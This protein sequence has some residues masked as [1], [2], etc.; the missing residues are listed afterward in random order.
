MNA[1]ARNRLPQLDVLPSLVRNLHGLP[2]VQAVYLAGSLGRGSGDEWSDVDLQIFMN[3][4]FSDFLSDAQ[5]QAVT[6]EPPVALERFK[7]GPKGWMHHMILTNGT[8]VDLLC[9]TELSAE[10][11]RSWIPLSADMTAPPKVVAR[12]AKD[13]MPKAIGPDEVVALVSR[14]WIAMHKHR[15]GMARRQD[16]AIWT[17]IH[18]SIALLI[19]LEFIAQTDRDCGD[20]TRMGIYDLSGVDAWLTQSG[21]PPRVT[22]FPNSCQWTDWKEQVHLLWEHGRA[23][24]RRLMQ[25]WPLTPDPSELMQVVGRDL[26]AW[27]AQSGCA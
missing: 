18:F 1:S 5:I 22:P 23:V 25:R 2:Q 14:Y 17:G 6:G 20:L 24:T 27:M 19:R 21:M 7:L 15:R 3:Q 10:E 4:S 13:W 9:R 16:L 12:H 11:T 26:A 8:L